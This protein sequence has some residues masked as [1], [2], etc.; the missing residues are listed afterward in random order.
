MPPHVSFLEDAVDEFLEA[1]AEHQS[2]SAQPSADRSLRRASKC[3]RG[4]T[5]ALEKGLKHGLSSVDP[6]LLIAR[7][8]R[9]LLVDLRRDLE[10]CAAPTL[11][12]SRRPFETITLSQT[13]ETLR[14]LRSSAIDPGAVAGFERALMR[15]VAFRNRAYHGEV[16]AEPDEL[17]AVVS[18]M[19]AHFS[20]VVRCTSP[21]WLTE[22]NLRNEQL[23]SRLKA[24]ET[25][26]DAN[27]QVLVDYLV[28]YGTIE[29]TTEMYCT[30]T[31]ESDVIRVLCGET[32]VPRTIWCHSDVPKT[33]A[34]GI[35]STFLTK[36]QSDARRTARSDKREFDGLTPFE[37]GELLLSKA[38]GWLG[39]N[40]SRI[41]PPH[42]YSAVILSKLIV[43]FADGESV[44]GVVSGELTC[45]PSAGRAPPNPVLISGQAKLT[46][47]WH[48]SE[49]LATAPPKPETTVR[50]FRLDL[51]LKA[52]AA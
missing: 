51:Q 46:S 17:I 39:L 40:L 27:W 32:N 34:A 41:T 45:Q 30:T 20:A 7:P 25:Q 29:L 1:F 28:R 42:L 9:S 14:D 12:C 37:S 5:L 50:S 26:V 3:L 2:L 49:D 21:A 36:L 4:F 33:S 15:L 19:L 52:P 31:V 16:Y 43:T 10:A 6:Y 8:D 24:I 18:E 11:F 22:L 47:E 13:W 44:T 38:P 48:H 23:L 35:F